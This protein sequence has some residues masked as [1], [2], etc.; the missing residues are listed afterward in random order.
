MRLFFKLKALRRDIVDKNIV[1][2]I[3]LEISTIE[4]LSKFVCVRFSIDPSQPVKLSL[5]GF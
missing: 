5:S 4:A 1:C 2:V 3:P